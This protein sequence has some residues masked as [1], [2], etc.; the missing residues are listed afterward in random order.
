[1]TQQKQT[2]EAVTPQQPGM[3]G[4]PY[5]PPMNYDMDDEISLVDLWR[6]LASRKWMIFFMTLLFTLGAVGYALNAPEIYKAE[7]MLAPVKDEGGGG[8]MASIAAQFGGL[9]SMAGVNLGEGGGSTEEAIAILQSRKFLKSFIE[10]QR[11]M[12]TLF[13]DLWDADSQQWLVDIEENT[14]TAWN[15]YA[16]FSS[17]LNISTDKKSGMVTLSIEWEDPEVAAE[18]ANLLVVR[19]NK[20]LKQ[21]AVQQA[22]KSIRYLKDQLATTSVVDMQQILYRLIEKQSNTIMLANVQEQYAFR[23]I[24]PA[25]VP[26][27]RS[28]PKRKLIVVLGAVLGG[29]FSVFL[30]FFLNFLKNQREEEVGNLASKAE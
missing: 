10:E 1:M 16:S 24:D 27:V 13:A 2:D 22:E 26:E 17:I 7:T 15:A 23:V 28:K 29:M 25:V 6:V 9:A 4:Y 30:A 19:L 20:H 11:L 5:Y 12:P 21:E 18:W 8:G 3:P 14:P